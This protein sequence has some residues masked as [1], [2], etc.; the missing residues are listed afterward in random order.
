[1][2]LQLRV[3][4]TLSRLEWIWSFLF[5]NTRILWNSWELFYKNS[6]RE[7]S[8]MFS[9]NCIF[10][11]PRTTDS[12]SISRMFR[13][14]KN[15]QMQIPCGPPCAIH[16]A[17]SICTCW[18]ADTDRLR[19]ILMDLHRVLTRI[20]IFWST[21]YVYRQVMEKL[22]VMLTLHQVFRQCTRFYFSSC[23][24]DIREG[25]YTFNSYV[26]MYIHTH[27]LNWNR[28]WQ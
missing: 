15:I 17:K 11:T 12:T 22:P 27:A 19:S 20:W 1:M 23:F 13:N 6:N 2:F 3:S 25:N 24:M 21:L 8:N 18:R 16:N 4:I 7:T 10:S 26:N 28:Y 9:L 14:G 5:S